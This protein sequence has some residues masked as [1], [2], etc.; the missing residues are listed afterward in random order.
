VLMGRP[1]SLEGGS[2][3]FEKRAPV[4]QSRVSRDWPAAGPFTENATEP[5]DRYADSD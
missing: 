4:W 1:D 5:N 3:A 2:A